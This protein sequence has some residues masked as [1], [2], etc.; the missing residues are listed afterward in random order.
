MLEL[1]GND[2]LIKAVL[3]REAC[4]AQNDCRAARDRTDLFQIDLARKLN[5]RALIELSAGEYFERTKLLG[6]L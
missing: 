3:T 1:T 6:L 5:D 2:A 4:N